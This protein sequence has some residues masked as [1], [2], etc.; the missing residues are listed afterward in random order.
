MREIT[1]NVNGTPHR[2]T[3]DDTTVLLDA[4]RQRVGVTNAR[5]G[6]SVV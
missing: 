3:V 1:L 4:L 6:K 2:V 5:E